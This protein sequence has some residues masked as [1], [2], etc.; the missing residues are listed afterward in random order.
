MI[1]LN[2][3]LGEEIGIPTDGEG[4]GENADEDTPRREWKF[5][6]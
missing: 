5:D 2:R 1:D 4:D 3:W 6:D